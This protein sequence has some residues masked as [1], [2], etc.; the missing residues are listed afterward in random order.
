M[1]AVTKRLVPFSEKL[2]TRVMLRDKNE[3]LNHGGDPPPLG[4]LVVS[5]PAIGPFLLR[6]HLPERSGSPYWKAG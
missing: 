4:S 1:E 2:F 6:I 5:Y 3:T